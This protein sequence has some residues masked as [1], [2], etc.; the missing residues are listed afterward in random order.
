M[1]WVGE[2]GGHGVEAGWD[3]G[4]ELTQAEG[5]PV[6]HPSLAVVGHPGEDVDDAVVQVAWCFDAAGESLRQGETDLRV[7]VVVCD[8]VEQS[9]CRRGVPGV[10]EGLD[11][12]LHHSWVAG[13]GEDVHQLG[14]DGG[15]VVGMPVDQVAEAV[16]L[17][18]E[19]VAGLGCGTT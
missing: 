8:V 14:H 19:Q 4:V 6:P 3:R 18:G 17:E 7:G 16:R 13:G 10:A 12:S 15:D 1:V 2:Q 5:G 11:G 9:G